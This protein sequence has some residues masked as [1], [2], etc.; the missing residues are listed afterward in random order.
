MVVIPDRHALTTY[1]AKDQSLQQSR[2]FARRTVAAILSACLSIL[3]QPALIFFVLLPRD[4]SGMHARHENPLFLGTLHNHLAT[5]GFFAGVRAPIHECPGIARIMQ[6]LQCPAM[7]Q[8][9]PKEVAFMGPLFQSAWK[10]QTLLPESFDGC[11]RRAH[12][13]KSLE[14]TTDTLLDLFV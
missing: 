3:A 10:A 2:S 14:E 13:L 11:Q 1:S 4:I 12:T 8:F 7:S 5:I 9:H 6:N